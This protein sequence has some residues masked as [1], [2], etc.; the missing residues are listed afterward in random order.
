MRGIALFVFFF[1]AS[2]SA[3]ALSAGDGER[4]KGEIESSEA[5]QPE[6]SNTVPAFPVQQGKETCH[7]DLSDELFGGVKE[8]C[9]DG[10]G[11]LVLKIPQ[12]LNP[13]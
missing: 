2:L 9:G 6:D 1:V 8:A 3:A 5:E 10:K 12:F 7:L 11:L 4:S 13:K